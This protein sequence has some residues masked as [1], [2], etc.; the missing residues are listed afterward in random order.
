MENF[1][2]RGLELLLLAAEHSQQN[3]V[4][5][6]DT[7]TIEEAEVIIEAQDTLEVNPIFEKFKESGQLQTL[8]NFGSNTLEYIYS[9]CFNFFELTSRRGPKPKITKM[10]GLVLLLIFYQNNSTL[11]LSNFQ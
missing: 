8:T 6:M 9:N 10:D 4:Q 11:F 3:L 5:Q 2:N 7:V 1:N